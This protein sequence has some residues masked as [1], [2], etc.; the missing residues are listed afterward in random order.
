MRNVA[1]PV[2]AAA[3]ALSACAELDLYDP[4]VDAVTT[5]ADGGRAVASVSQ[6]A[7]LSLAVGASPGTEGGF[8]Y[9][10]SRRNAEQRIQAA[11]REER[12][13]R[14]Q[15]RAAAAAP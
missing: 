15:A 6:D 4:Y 10:W 1:L 5:P 8:F 13:L 3:L 2:L 14:Q 7:G 9:D 11:Q 12:I